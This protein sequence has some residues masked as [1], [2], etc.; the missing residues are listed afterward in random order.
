MEAAMSLT[1]L[2]TIGGPNG[3]AEIY[4]YEPSGIDAL[5]D[6]IGHVENKY[7]LRF[8]GSLV[9]HYDDLHEARSEANELTGNNDA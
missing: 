6:A 4:E 5:V 3:E 8:D 9:G 2:E 1:L 7:M